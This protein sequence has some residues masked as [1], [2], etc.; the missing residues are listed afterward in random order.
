MKKIISFYLDTD[1]VRIARK[2][3]NEQDRSLSY[4]VNSLLREKFL[5]G[6]PKPK[7]YLNPDKL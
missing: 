5:K 3:A 7:K 6:K 2:K 1:V 4:L